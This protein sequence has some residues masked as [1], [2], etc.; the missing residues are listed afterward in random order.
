MLLGGGTEC[1]KE[2]AEI[3]MLSMALL[4]LSV[5][6]KLCNTD[7]KPLRGAKEWC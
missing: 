7:L 5:K 2:R 6:Q 4:P 3:V 1:A